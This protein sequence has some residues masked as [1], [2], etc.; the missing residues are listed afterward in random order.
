MVHNFFDK[1]TS[2]RTVKNEDIS[3]KELAEDL[4]KPIIR[5]LNK[6]KARST[7]ID[8]IW[9]TYL[10]DMQLIIKFNLSFLLCAVNAHGLF[11]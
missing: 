5:K 9:G 11:L 2:G 10:A 4:Q 8:N 6:R 1:N 7:F 3:N